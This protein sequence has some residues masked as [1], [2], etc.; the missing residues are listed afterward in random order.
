LNHDGNKEFWYLDT[1]GDL[2]SYNIV[3]GHF[4]KGDSVISGNALS[5]KGDNSISKGDFD[6][7]GIDDIAVLYTLNS[8]APLFVLK[9]YSYK[10]NKISEIFSKIFV[11]QSSAF[12]GFNFTQANQSIR[13]VDIDNDN[14]VELIVSLFPYTYIFK[15]SAGGDKLVFYQEG[16]NNTTIF[17]GDLNHNGV[18]EIGLQGAKGYTFYEFGPANK[19]A[20]PSFVNG[21]SLD[22]NHVYIQWK[23]PASFFFIFRGVSGNNLSLHDSTNSNFYYDS[24]N[25]KDTTH[26]FYSIKAYGS[27]KPIPLSDLSAIID[28]YVHKPARIVS[29][30]NKSSK[31]ILVKFSELIK[32]KIENLKAFEL[33]S[34]V[35]PNSISAASQ[36][37]Y[38]LTFRD[39]L[40]LGI[41]KISVSNL[42]DFYN[43]PVKNDTTPFNVENIIEASYLMISNHEIINP[44]LIKITFNLPVD[45]ISAKN[46]ANYTFDPA[47]SV[48][49]VTI[50]PTRLIIYL[51]LEKKKPVGSVGIQYR[52]KIVNVVSSSE[53]GNIPIAPETGSYIVLT[54]VT[55]NLSD[56]YVYP[57]PVKINNGSGKMTFANLPSKVKIIIFNINGIRISEISESTTTGGVDYNLRD[58]NNDLI[59]SG[60]YIYRIVRLDG[61]NNEVETKIGKFAVIR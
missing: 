35:Y 10:N 14:K 5:I 37:S 3:Q 26:Y 36:Q 21:N 11:D 46:I 24:L 8:V 31:S 40:P 22:S 28:V 59:S 43:S 15:S 4:L 41:N 47:N 9:I 54:G 12:L 49:S 58:K 39:N 52:L 18:K 34:N 51:N 19:T 27:D 13:F 61:S 32:T 53:S 44:F 20:P 2:L 29:I 17:A 23:S 42:N 7:D 57:S 50:D 30:E 33:L 38:L 56:I 6:G 1:N 48:E 16:T 55:Q 25:V 45:S 60:I